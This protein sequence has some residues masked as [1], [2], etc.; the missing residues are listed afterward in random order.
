MK[1]LSDRNTLRIKIVSLIVSFALLTPIVVVSAVD[2]DEMSPNPAIVSVTATESAQNTE[3][4]TNT[5]VT[6]VATTTEETTTEEI[7]TEEIT[8][9]KPTEED[10]TEDVEEPST[11]K[12][13]YD[14]GPTK[15]NNFY[16]E[17]DLYILSHL[18]YG[19]A[20][21]ESDECQLAV[22]S[23]VLNRVKSNQF[24]NSISG[25][26]FAPG[27]YACTWDGNYDKEPDARAIRN[28]RYLL[29]NGSQLP[30][31]VVFQAQFAQGE[32]YKI[33][34]GEYFCYG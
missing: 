34:D 12:V 14:S 22:G 27:Q 2:G 7:T 31:G 8:T 15:V 20:G 25:V 9:E 17:D 18:I 28:A 11:Q 19:E 1:Y 30:D 16:D 23:V 21:G 5:T 24:P 3:S 6:D 32:I 13:V 26:V 33:I 29:E 4:I 10:I